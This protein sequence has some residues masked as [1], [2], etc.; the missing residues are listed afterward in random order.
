M[1]RE[2]EPKLSRKLFDV[3]REFAAHGTG[4]Y[5]QWDMLYIHVSSY[6]HRVRRLC[7]L[8]ER[9]PTSE[10]T[11][12]VFHLCDILEYDKFQKFV[13]RCPFSFHKKKTSLDFDKRVVSFPVSL[14][15]IRLNYPIQFFTGFSQL[16]LNWTPATHLQLPKRL[17][18]EVKRVVWLTRTL[19]KDIRLRIV[20]AYILLDYPVQN[21][22][23]AGDIQN[24]QTELQK[25]R[26]AWLNNKFSHFGGAKTKTDALQYMIQENQSEYWWKELS[27]GHDE[28]D[29]LYSFKVKC[30][31]D[32]CIKGKCLKFKSEQILTKWSPAN[33]FVGWFDKPFKADVHALLLLT[34]R[35]PALKS[36]R[37]RIISKLA[38]LYQYYYE[39][40]FYHSGASKW[41]LND[42][43]E[44]MPNKSPEKRI[45][46]S[47][48][49]EERWKFLARNKSFIK[50][51]MVK[52]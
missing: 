10:R 35:I 42:L 29:C 23:N 44:T 47:A 21:L 28:A 36:V 26:L 17:C 37:L 49:K 52:K 5:L 1:K 20:R 11:N 2:R 22:A 43:Y 12:M 27:M 19:C 25:V 24:T 46:K 31:K 40:L 9:V 7:E 34:Q 38:A 32:G 18:Q 15:F 45:S 16:W 41:L 4:P 6:K 14:A 48:T 3:A 50:L 51:L 39:F 33:H 13:K 30:M 8:A